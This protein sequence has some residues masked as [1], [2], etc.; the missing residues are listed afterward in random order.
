MQGKDAKK[1]GNR[2]VICLSTLVKN[3][4]DV[5]MCISPVIENINH[6]HLSLEQKQYSTPIWEICDSTHNDRDN[7]EVLSLHHCMLNKALLIS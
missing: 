1:R 3:C 7:C 2:F 5:V 6:L 4:G